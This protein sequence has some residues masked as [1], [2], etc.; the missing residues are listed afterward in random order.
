MENMK[1]TQEMVDSFL[2]TKNLDFNVEMVPT[3]G[4]VDGEYKELDAYVPMRTDNNEFLSKGGLSKD[5]VPIQNRDAFRVIT[6]MAGVT[7]I[8][9][10]NGGQWG[11]G[12]GVFAQISLGDMNIGNG[13][14]K[15]GKYLSV[16]NSHDG[17]RALNIL[18]TPYRYVC[19]NQI[20][21]SI[22]HANKGENQIISIRHNSSADERIEQLIH[23]VSI[24]NEAF[25]Q[26]EETYNKL[27]NLKINEEYV[28]E[29]L[30]RL[31]PLN[32]TEG[33]G[34][35]IWENNIK[36]VRDRYMSADRGRIERGTAWNLYNAIQ[37]TYQH[38]S[39]NSSNKNQSVLVGTIAK[40]SSNALSAVLEICSSEHIPH[41][42]QAEID[43]M[44]N[45]NF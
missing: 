14:D 35:T 36:A 9:L 23:T 27:A 32:H 24:A 31:F 28:K 21:K 1:V 26:S 38:D 22:N 37:G 25:E 34:K 15:V 42:V 10:K 8:E 11:G 3:Y 5:F 7:N 43:A 13:G 29:T 44:I 6:Q 45:G 17:S 33:R 4:K 19:M 16:V 18:I 2:I 41:T 40:Q 30:Q 12:V 39:R 20:A